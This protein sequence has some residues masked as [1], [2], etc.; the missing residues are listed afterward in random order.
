M[1]IGRNVNKKFV[2]YKWK[3]CLTFF[4]FWIIVKIIMVLGDSGW[5]IVLRL[6]TPIPSGIEGS[7]NVN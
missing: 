2:Y 6:D 3:I 5:Y 7:E 4:I 1:E